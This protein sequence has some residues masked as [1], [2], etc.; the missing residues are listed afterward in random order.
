MALNTREVVAT[1]D[2]ERERKRKR[3]RKREEAEDEFESERMMRL[4]QNGW[5]PWS[6]LLR[7]CHECRES[8]QRSVGWPLCG[9]Q[10]AIMCDRCASIRRRSTN[11]R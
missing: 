8:G 2:R 3:K 10:F 1:V 11:D 9:G 6:G 5:N 7:S 4:D